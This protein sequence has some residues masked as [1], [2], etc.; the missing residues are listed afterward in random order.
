MCLN[1]DI[2]EYLLRLD[3]EAIARSLLTKGYVRLPWDASWMR[4]NVVVAYEGLENMCAE[5]ASRKSTFVRKAADARTGLFL[6]ERSY[7][8]YT[9]GTEEVL[10]DEGAPVCD[11]RSFFEACGQLN[12]AAQQL[13]CTLARL[14]DEALG[15]EKVYGPTR[16]PLLSVRIADGNSLTKVIRY[17]SDKPSESAAELHRDGSVFTIHWHATT[18]GLVVYDSEGCVADV[19]ETTFEQILIFFGERAHVAT[20]GLYMRGLSHE[21]RKDWISATQ[22]KRDRLAIVSF[23][24]FS[25]SEEEEQRQRSLS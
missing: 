10:S 1:H 7:F 13:G 22:G 19:N 21:V 17:D 15:G 2:E 8:Q 12:T 11:Y 6:K 5:S 24:R 16:T 4:R 25:L 18:P 3:T 9:N 14:T 23:V 20:G